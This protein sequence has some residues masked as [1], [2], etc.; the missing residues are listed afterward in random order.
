MVLALA[1]IALMVA[2]FNASWWVEDEP[3]ASRAQVAAD[4]STIW[5]QDGI[6]FATRLGTAEINLADDR[7]S[8]RDLGLPDDGT[9]PVEFSVPVVVATQGEDGAFG[10]DEVSQLELVTVDGRLM[11]ADLVFPRQYQDVRRR[12][13]ELSGRGGWPADALQELETQLERSLRKSEGAAASGRIGPNVIGDIRVTIEVTGGD[14]QPTVLR[15]VSE[16]A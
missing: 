4:G 10:Q 8:A 15:F 7:P 11:R 12:V 6:D 13:I 3:V 2:A 9:T 1:L 16:P 14:A 5:T